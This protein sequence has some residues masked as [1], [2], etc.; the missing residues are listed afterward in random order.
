ME[1]RDVPLSS[2]AYNSIS[3]LCYFNV[4]SGQNKNFF[5]PEDN[6][7]AADLSEVIGRI[8]RYEYPVNPDRPKERSHYRPSGPI[9]PEDH[10]PYINPR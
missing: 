4:I 7:T 10:E 1:F 3:K 9:K 2:P 5:R 6:V 8:Q